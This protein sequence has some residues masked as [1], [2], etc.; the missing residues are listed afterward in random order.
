MVVIDVDNQYCEDLCYSYQVV[1]EDD[2]TYSVYQSWNIL[3]GKYL[4]RGFDNLEDAW[5]CLNQA[6]QEYE[7][8]RILEQV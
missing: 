1:R 2:Q 8:F 3:R 7:H 6:M 5:I 4:G